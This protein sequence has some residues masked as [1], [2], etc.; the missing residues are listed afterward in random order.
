MSINKVEIIM[1]SSQNKQSC[2]LQGKHI[3]VVSESFIS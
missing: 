2:D 3:L 1:H